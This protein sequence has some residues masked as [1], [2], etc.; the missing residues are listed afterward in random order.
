M[1][2][3]SA[4][5]KPSGSGILPM[6]IIT[7]AIPDARKGKLPNPPGIPSFL[8]PSLSSSCCWLLLLL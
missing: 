4:A 1:D 2:M 5:R 3:V 8:P 7:A 6:G